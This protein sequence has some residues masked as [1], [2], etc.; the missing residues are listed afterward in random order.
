MKRV[1]SPKI[2]LLVSFVLI[3]SCAIAIGA[4]ISVPVDIKPGSCTNP[5]N[6]KSNGVL[7]LVILGGDQT[8][9]G[10]NVTTINPKTIA[11]EASVTDKSTGDTYDLGNLK[12]PFYKKVAIG[13]VTSPPTPATCDEE[14]PD[15]F[16]DLIARYR[17]TALVNVLN[18]KLKNVAGVNLADG[19]KVVLTV[20]ATTRTTE[21]TITGSDTILIK[22]PGRK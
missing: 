8:T 10:V 1:A 20:T 18:K 19:D 7:P 14:T 9:G 17:I 12:V 4:T 3:C 16:T 11:L 22:K 2:L 5:V 21:D 6:I 13:D 15:G